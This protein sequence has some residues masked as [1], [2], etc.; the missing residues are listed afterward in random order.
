MIVVKMVPAKMPFK[1][2]LKR[3]QKDT[4]AGSFTVTDSDC[5]LRTRSRLSSLRY[6]SRGRPSASAVT[7]RLS[8]SR[9]AVTRKPPELFV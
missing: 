6:S 3:V 9:L 8:P 5:P 7:H 2:P 1:Q 4:A